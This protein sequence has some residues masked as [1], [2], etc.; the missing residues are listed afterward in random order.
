[1][2]LFLVPETEEAHERTTIEEIKTASKEELNKITKNDFLKC[3]ENWKKKLVQVYNTY[4][5]GTN[6]RNRARPR[7]SSKLWSA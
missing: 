6:T 5:F 3:F 4:I 1:M 2:S 7:T